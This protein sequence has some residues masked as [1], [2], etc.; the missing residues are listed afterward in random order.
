[1]NRRAFLAASLS[2][3]L[4]ALVKA[5][6]K[7]ENPADK[8]RAK[9]EE[10]RKQHEVPALAGGMIVGE[11][12]H[13]AVVGV[14]KFGDE[15]PAKDGDRFHLGSCTKSMTATLCG[16]LVEQGK[17]GWKTTLGELGGHL[18]DKLH[19]QLKPVTL[20]QLLAH[21]SG[22]NGSSELAEA[23]FAKS[24]ESFGAARTVREQRAAYVE[25][26][27]QQK[28]LTPPGEKYAYSNRGYIV[29]G[30]LLERLT[31]QPWE[32]LIRARLF[33][34]LGMKSA[35]FGAMGRAGQIEEPWQHVR[36][37]KTLTPIEPSRWA[38]NPAYLGPAGTVHASLEDWAK[39][40][41]LHLL[42]E[43][44]PALLKAETFRELHRSRGDD[45]A[46][47]WMLAERAWAGG[48]VLLHGGSNT[49]SFCICWL[50]P[51]KQFAVFAA[52]NLAD[53]SA[54]RACDQACAAAIGIGG[55]K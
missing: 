55:K 20:E 42:G 52:C 51:E 45:Y 24:L 50:A 16:M 30:Y 19:E 25:R 26:A 27:L 1:M 29:A 28:P 37:G 35:G 44:Q 48:R 54:S 7:D 41:R 17:L 2:G 43:K 36:Q 11:K 5:A 8:L 3:L 15:T 23:I 49:L 22:L 18:G 46:L 31:D 40:L 9:L 13:T 10:L 32:E 12:I 21:R 53:A 14:R 47:G 6:E 38:D 39:Y 34:P 33:E 4:P